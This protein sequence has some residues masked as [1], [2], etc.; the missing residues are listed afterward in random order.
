MEFNEG[1]YEKLEPI[2][3]LWE[4]LKRDGS[5]LNMIPNELQRISD[6]L[7]DLQEI[8]LNRGCSTCIGDGLKTVFIQFDKYENH[9]NSQRVEAPRERR[10]RIHDKK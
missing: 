6:V 10:T 5:V 8:R 1:H 4:A 7:Y 3:H 9:K 2:K